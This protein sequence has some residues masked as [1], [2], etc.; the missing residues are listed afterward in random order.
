MDLIPWRYLALIRVHFPFSFS[1]RVFL[2]FRIG[3]SA[4]VSRVRA[5]AYEKQTSG[6]KSKKTKTNIARRNKTHWLNI[7]NDKKRFFPGG[8]LCVLFLA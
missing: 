6:L 1:G 3:A 4:P 5:V 8:Q 2:S 7:E